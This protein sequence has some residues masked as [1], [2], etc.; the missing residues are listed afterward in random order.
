MQR[1]RP[2]TIPDDP[3]PLAGDAAFAA[4]TGGGGEIGGRGGGAA[5]DG[6]GGITGG[7]GVMGRGGG[8][9][10]GL[11]GEGGRA[12]RGGIGTGCGRGRTS[13]GRAPA[14]LPAIHAA[15]M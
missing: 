1:Y 4:V 12:A 11:P 9:C 15:A 10:V 6:F 2:P 5:L 3:F 14:F 13:V 8:T 7:G